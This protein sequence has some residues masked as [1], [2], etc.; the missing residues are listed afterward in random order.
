[1]EK[2]RWKDVIGYK[3]LYQVSNLGRIKSFH[4]Y[5]KKEGGRILS[6]PINGAGYVVILLCKNTKRK[7]FRLHRLIAQAFIKNTDN[8]P[9]IN[10]KNEIKNDNRVENLEWCTASENIKHHYKYFNTG[11]FVGEKNNNA[12]LKTSEVRQIKT[13]F[14]NT[15]L[16]DQE[17]SEMFNISRNVIYNIRTGRTWSHVV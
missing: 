5:R 11:N 16:L 2:E 10:H 1:M 7:M 8:K 17:I 15:N 14:K 3:G 12:K 6:E 9:Y 13:I 4:N